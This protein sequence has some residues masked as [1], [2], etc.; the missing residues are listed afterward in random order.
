M[1]PVHHRKSRLLNDEATENLWPAFID[2]T[3]TIAL[4]LILFVLVLLA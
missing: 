3:T 1:T 4:I 2:L